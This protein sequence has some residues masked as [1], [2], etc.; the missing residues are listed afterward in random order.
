MDFKALPKIEVGTTLPKSNSSS[1]NDS[2][3][4]AH[5]TGSISRQALHTIWQQKHALH[6][7]QL[8]DPLVVM[9]E[10]KKDYNLQ[11]FFPL[12]TSYIYGLLPD[13]P[14]VRYTTLSVLSSFAADGVVYLELRTTPRATPLLSAEAYVL[15]V[16]SAVEEFERGEGRM[17]TRL[18]LCVDRKMSVEEAEEV[19]SMAVKYKDRGVVGVD[20]C[21]NP[22]TRPD[23]EIDIFTS[24]FREAREKGLHITVHFAEAPVSASEREQQILLSWQP[25]RLGHCIW[26]SEES[27]R[28]I[29][30]RGLCLELCLSCNVL[31]GMC[32]NEED[33]GFTGHHFGMW[34]REPKVRVSLGTDDVG[35]FG[36]PLSEEYSHA[37]EH[38]G[39]SEAEVRKLAWDGID[40]I[41]GGDAEKERLRA[42]LL[43]PSVEGEDGSDLAPSRKR[44]K[45]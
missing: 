32:R 18:I 33:R 20:L 26:E 39:L 21:G 24:A 8:E 11:T 36:S 40:A 5:L 43:T 22:A 27:R 44:S 45:T 10:D 3:L 19:V 31:A 7:T 35:V 2:Q 28:V 9:P 23:G 30:E 6:L 41:F 25:E 13:G 16:L 12:F 37:A 1:T 34:S 38:F 29:R 15:E 14:S 42:M 17:R 4:H